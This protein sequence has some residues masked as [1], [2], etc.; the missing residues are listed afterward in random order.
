MVGWYLIHIYMS[1]VHSIH[2]IILPRTQQGNGTPFLGVFFRDI[3]WSQHL[4]FGRALYVLDGVKYIDLVSLMRAGP[5]YDHNSKMVRA[6][7]WLG[8]LQCLACAGML[9]RRSSR[10]H[11]SVTM[12]LVTM[13]GRWLPWSDKAG[14]SGTVDESDYIPLSVRNPIWSGGL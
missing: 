14:C 7:W 4:D 2:S 11:R 6:Q 1:I 9:R 12:P 5:L 10:L 8:E 3:V 13:Y